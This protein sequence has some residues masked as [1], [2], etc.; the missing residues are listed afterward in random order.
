MSFEKKE[1]NKSETQKTV[2]RE[3]TYQSFKRS[4][5]VDENINTENIQAKYENGILALTLPKKEEAK[6]ARKLTS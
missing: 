1:E 5:N 6:P 2:R 3:F 4:F